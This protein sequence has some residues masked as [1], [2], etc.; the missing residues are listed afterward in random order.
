M[1]LDPRLLDVL[2]CPAD[3]GPLLY[4]ADERSLYNPRERL[5]YRVQDGIPAMLIEDAEKTDDAE[6][7]RLMAEASDNAVATTDADTPGRPDRRHT[8]SSDTAACA[9]P[10]AGRDV[11]ES[12]AAHQ[13]PEPGD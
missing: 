11:D 10:S 13:S 5:R 1:S 12:P 4:F 7:G 2:A 8:G 6:H 9:D 3:K